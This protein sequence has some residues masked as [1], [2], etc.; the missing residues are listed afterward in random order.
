MRGSLSAGCAGEMFIQSDR[1]STVLQ[2]EYGMQ[3]SFYCT[4]FPFVL[5]GDCGIINKQRT[6]LLWVLLYRSGRAGK[7]LGNKIWG[8]GLCELL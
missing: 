8:K 2:P 1:E 6:L 5:Q 3:Y 7:T 4:D